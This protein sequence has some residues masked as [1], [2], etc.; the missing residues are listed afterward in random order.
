M[1]FKAW[2]PGQRQPDPARCLVAALGK[3]SPSALH[4][5]PSAAKHRDGLTGCP[6]QTTLKPASPNN[7]P[8]PSPWVW[9]SPSGPYVR[10]GGAESPNC[11]WA[12][13]AARDTGPFVR[14]AVR[15]HR[16]TARSRRARMWSFRG[17]GGHPL[18][19]PFIWGPTPTPAAMPEPKSSNG[20]GPGCSQATQETPVFSLGT[21]SVVTSPLTAD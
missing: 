18:V 20:E 13:C 10:A 9:S 1:R 17:A 19:R 12:L 7:L 14:G 15:R 8:V 3:L 11:C 5:L 2:M 16:K 21:E 6:Q 4:L